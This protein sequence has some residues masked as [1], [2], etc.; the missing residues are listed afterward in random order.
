LVISNRQVV[1]HSDNTTPFIAV[2]SST[3]SNHDKKEENA[4]K[5]R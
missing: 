1:T 5:N 2:L 3:I 4:E